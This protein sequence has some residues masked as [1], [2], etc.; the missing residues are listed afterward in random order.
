MVS[1]G[2]CGCPH[3]AAK[4]RHGTAVSARVARGAAER[5]KADAE[6]T[7]LTD[8]GL[9]NYEGGISRPAAALR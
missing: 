9:V 4:G 2:C 1:S 6:M 8:G 7:V 5:N 3:P